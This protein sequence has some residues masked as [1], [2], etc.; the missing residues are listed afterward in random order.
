MCGPIDS[1]LGIKTELS[2]NFM[3]THLR[4]G[5]EIAKGPCKVQGI[6]AETNDSTGKALSIERFDLR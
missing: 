6:F 4:A 3:I 1:V 5:M 2:T